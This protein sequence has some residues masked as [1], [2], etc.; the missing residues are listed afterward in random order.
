MNKKI[1]LSLVTIFVLGVSAFP[2][3][4][5]APNKVPVVAIIDN[6]FPDF[7][8]MISTE[9]DGIVHIQN[10]MIV[11]PI[12]LYL[13]DNPTPIPVDYVDYPV[14]ILYNPKRGSNG[15]SIMEFTEVWALDGGTFVGTAH[16]KIDGFLFDFTFTNMKSHIIL[17]GT[18]D[19]EG[20]IINLKMDWYPA[21]PTTYGYFGTWL[22][23]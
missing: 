19:Y 1:L 10:L 6:M 14:D 12:S 11:G 3:M 7:T 15:W 2:V 4:A 23:S 9:T 22:K 21:D 20:Q 16:V 13:G 5:K 17:Q 18:G 8:N